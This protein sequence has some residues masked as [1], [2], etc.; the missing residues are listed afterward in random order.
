MQ[1]EPIIGGKGDPG[2]RKQGKNVFGDMTDQ[3]QK[4]L[5]QFTEERG[6]TYIKLLMQAEF[7]NRMTIKGNIIR[8]LNSNGFGGD[9]RKVGEAFVY[10]EKAYG[11]SKRR[12]GTKSVMH[13]YKIALDCAYAGADADTVIIA[14]FHDS[15]E[16]GL[17]SMAEI[18][19]RLGGGIAKSVSCVTDYHKSE[20]DKKAENDGIGIGAKTQ[21]EGLGDYLDLKIKNY[22]LYLDD[23]YNSGDIRAMTVKFFD[24]MEN[25]K[26]LRHEKDALTRHSIARKALLH[27]PF[28]KAINYNFFEFVRATLEENCPSELVGEAR[29]LSEKSLNQIG[30]E[31]A[32]AAFIKTLNPFS[33]H[34]ILQKPDS[35]SGVPAF[36]SPT[37]LEGKQGEIIM[38]FPDDFPPD[39]VLETCRKIAPGFDWEA[40]GENPLP[41]YFRASYFFEAKARGR[42]NAQNPANAKALY[43]MLCFLGRTLQT[44]YVAHKTELDAGV[45]GDTANNGANPRSGWRETPFQT[46][47]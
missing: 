25:V 30:Y 32:G 19:S 17:C 9:A 39:R 46:G 43:D 37:S 14:L 11:D 5:K 2:K 33:F 1:N 3:F 18:E 10:L 38:E 6:F 42:Q 36:Y 20:F 35:Y 16:D 28:W 45:P 4:A 12:D 26:S 27:L 44:D 41:V 29:G 15:V 34:A 8:K 21:F 7:S 40:S 24:T 23:L 31:K 13:P 47:I 22:K